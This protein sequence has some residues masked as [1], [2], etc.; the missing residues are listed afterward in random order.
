M[1]T[2]FSSYSESSL[3]DLLWPISSS[4]TILVERVC[5]DFGAFLWWF[6]CISVV[7]LLHF[8]GGFGAFLLTISLLVLLIQY[9][10]QLGISPVILL[11]HFPGD[12][13]AILLTMS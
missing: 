7:I 9:K 3:L 5:G 13:G 2:L 11:E 10:L 6:C 12:F 8:C 1:N 4:L